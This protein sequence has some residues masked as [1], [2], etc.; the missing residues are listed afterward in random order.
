MTSISAKTPDYSP[1]IS[2]KNLLRQ[3]RIS[4]KS[5]HQ[6]KQKIY[7]KEY[8]D[9]KKKKK[10]SISAKHVFRYKWPIENTLLSY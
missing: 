9:H 1:W 2:A 8:N 6:G 3:I 7:S 5:T 4:C 10:T